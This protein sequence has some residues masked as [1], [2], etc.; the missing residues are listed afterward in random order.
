MGGKP[1]HLGVSVATLGDPGR[2]GGATSA[3]VACCLTPAHW[4]PAPQGSGGRVATR[5][6]GRSTLT[7][8]T[9]SSARAIADGAAGAGLTVTGSTV[10]SARAIAAGAAGAGLTV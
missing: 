4:S 9:V 6:R 3:V 10:S 8:S 5:A 7:G 2:L 1:P